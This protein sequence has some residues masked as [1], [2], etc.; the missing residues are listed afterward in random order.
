MRDAF[1]V[2]LLAADHE[3]EGAVVV[4]ERGLCL[5]EHR[6]AGRD[7]LA[8]LERGFHYVVAEPRPAGSGGQREA[9][10]LHD[11]LAAMA[12]GENSAGADEV[13]RLITREK[14][15]CVR[16]DICGIDLSVG[17]LLFMDENV[18]AQLVQVVHVKWVH[19]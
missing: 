5:E 19:L 3:A 11:V 2:E 12:G 13:P 9:A 17:A 8:E 1:V 4:R 10:E 14:V 7:V 16:S 15:K 6:K 18:D